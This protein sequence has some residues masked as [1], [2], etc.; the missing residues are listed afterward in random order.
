MDLQTIKENILKKKY[1]SR[2]DFLGD[3]NQIVEN[4][5]IFNGEVDVFTQK[6]NCLRN[7]YLLN[8]LS[9]LRF[10]SR[11]LWAT[12]GEGNGI[13]SPKLFWLTVR[14]NCSS[15]WEKFWDH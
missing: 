15:N 4:S 11:A 14:K 1:H 7:I 5:A 6:V 8:I 9:K 13:S 3:I 10:F 12:F 2:Q